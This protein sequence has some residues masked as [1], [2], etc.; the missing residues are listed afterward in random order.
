MLVGVVPFFPSQQS[1]E[2]VK[3]MN[4]PPNPNRDEH[5]RLASEGNAAAGRGDYPESQRLWNEAAR[6]KARGR[7]AVE[8]EMEARQ[9]RRASVNRVWSME[10]IERLKQGQDDAKAGGEG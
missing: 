9:A 5:R 6:L 3:I 8:T 1:K 4:R 2:T 7:V 10:E